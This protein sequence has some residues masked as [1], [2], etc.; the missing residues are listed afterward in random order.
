MARR[1]QAEKEFIDRAEISKRVTRARLAGQCLADF[2]RNIRPLSVRRRA[3][4]E[5]TRARRKAVSAMLRLGDVSG[6]S[7]N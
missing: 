1:E 4:A 5:R 6:S 2:E 3:A 7:A